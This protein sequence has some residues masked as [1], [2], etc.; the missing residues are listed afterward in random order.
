[1]HVSY[2]F[3]YS[4]FLLYYANKLYTQKK[5]THRH[6]MVMELIEYPF[7]QKTLTNEYTQVPCTF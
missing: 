7:Y 4:S 5:K 1:M 6:S 3:N 2:K